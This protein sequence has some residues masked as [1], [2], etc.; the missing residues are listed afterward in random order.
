MSRISKLTT[1]LGAVALALSLGSGAFAQQRMSAEKM[2]MLD[3]TTTAMQKV[4]VYRVVSNVLI[5][6]TG[7]GEYQKLAIPS[8]TIKHNG[9]SVALSDLQPGAQLGA[10]EVEHFAAAA[11]TLTV[12]QADGYTVATDTTVAEVIDVIRPVS[13]PTSAVSAAPSLPSTASPLP[14]VGLVGAGLLALGGGMSVVR[15]RLQR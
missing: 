5:V 12:E 8:G 13:A 4:T 10:V 2:P 15:R 3:V 11:Q 7:G 9:A 14:W 6:K 1:L